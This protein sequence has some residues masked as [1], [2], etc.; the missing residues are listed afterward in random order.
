MLDM[1]T[2]DK[3]RGR[4]WRAWTGTYEVTCIDPPSAICAIPEKAIRFEES[5]LV[6]DIAVRKNPRLEKIQQSF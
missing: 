4:A 5:L 1:K 6:V 3:P 2:E